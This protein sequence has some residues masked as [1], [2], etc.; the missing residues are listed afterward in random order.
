MYANFVE[1]GAGIYEKCLAILKQFN[2]Q[3]TI[4]KQTSMIGIKRP[5]SAELNKVIGFFQY[6]G[7]IAAQGI[8]SR[9]GT[10]MYELYELH[11]SALI[12]RNV[13]FSSRSLSI[14]NYCNA[15][16]N[17]P[18]H[19]YPRHS[20]TSILQSLGGPEIFA[21]ALPPCPSCKT[22][23]LSE[24]SKF[25][26]SCGVKLKDLSIFDS[27]VS[28]GIESLPI[29]ANRVASIKSNSKIRNIKDI[30]MD[31]DNRQLFKVKMIGPYWA[32]KIKNYAEEFIA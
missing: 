6:S 5:V 15:F 24:E 32:K 12:D 10:G 16:D 4:F 7:L 21:L 20:E 8:S 1:N 14:D 25:C 13:F 30:L 27:I 28:Q 26:S 31:T 23:R 17:R 2:R 9:G 29:T 18:N 3:G 19:Y 22:P 11:Y